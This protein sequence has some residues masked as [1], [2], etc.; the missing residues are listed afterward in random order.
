MAHAQIGPRSERLP[1][2]EQRDNAGMGH[3]MVM[4]RPS[5]SD[6]LLAGT[7]I[8]GMRLSWAQAQ[9]LCRSG[10]QG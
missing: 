8:A 7:L 10:I 2:I 1:R 3:R 9:H 6:D 4:I 5:P